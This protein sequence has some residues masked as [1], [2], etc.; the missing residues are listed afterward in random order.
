[1]GAAVG[2]AHEFEADAADPVIRADTAGNTKI[3]A[4]DGQDDLDLG[5]A[6]E[7]EDYVRGETAAG[8]AEVADASAKAESSSQYADFGGPFAGKAGRSAP[9]HF[10]VK[11]HVI[12]RKG[13]LLRFGDIWHALLQIS[14]PLNGANS[15]D[16]PRW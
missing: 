8:G 4:I 15:G 14:W 11:I 7:L 1:M 16:D 12:F 6:F 10:I 2:N 5:A 9:F 3:D 13:G